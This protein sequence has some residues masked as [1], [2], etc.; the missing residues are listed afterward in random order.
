METKSKIFI[1]SCF[2]DPLGINL[3]IRTL[4]NN[5]FGEN[6]WMAERFKSLTDTLLPIDN[7]EFCIDAVSQCEFFVAFISTRIGSRVIIDDSIQECSF[8]EM[9]LFV[10]VLLQKQILIFQ[11]DNYNPGPRIIRLLNLLK[12]V[13]PDGFKIVE[14]K[15]SEYEIIKELE[16]LLTSKKSKIYKIPTSLYVDSIFIERHRKYN[17][18]KELP[19]INFLDN[20]LFDSK[21]NMPDKESFETIL[22]KVKQTDNYYYK[23]CLLWMAIRKLRRVPYFNSKYEDFKQY[24]IQI[25]EEWAS[26]SAWYDLH[27]HIYFGYLATSV[28]LCKIKSNDTNFNPLHGTFGSAYYSIAKLS[29]ENKFNILSQLALP[30][31]NCAID[32]NKEIYSIGVR[33]SIYREMGDFRNSIIDFRNLLLMPETNIDSYAFNLNELGY[34]LYLSGDKK[35][36]ELMEKSIGLFKDSNS[37]S[38]VRAMRKL[39][40]AYSK[41]LKFS[42]AI[43]L[44][45]KSR[46]ISNKI[47]AYPKMEFEENFAYKIYRLK[48]K[49]KSFFNL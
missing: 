46:E 23:L 12:R 8:F 42:S 45:G 30:H 48:I 39:A 36:V 33:G 40:I 19:N 22:I 49:T 21:I 26:A 27:G 32:I 44:I 29:K 14:G 11:L 9:E 15:K 24:W 16:K 25:L 43:D 41:E 47:R 1:S 17:I 4:V 6:V 2:S 31:I 37:T 5:K 13:S 35:G 20:F 28:T 34:S 10:A 38:I 18:Y 3:N 7:V